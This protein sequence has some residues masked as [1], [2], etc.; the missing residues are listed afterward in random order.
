MVI[1]DATVPDLRA[2]RVRGPT[3][4]KERPRPPSKIVQAAVISTSTPHNIPL[5]YSPVTEA[6]T[7]Q[8]TKRPLQAS[9]LIAKLKLKLKRNLV[10]KNKKLKRTKKIAIKTSKKTCNQSH[11]QH[12]DPIGMSK[13]MAQ[14][15]A[16]HAPAPKKKLVGQLVKNCLLYTSPS[17]RDRQKSRMPSSA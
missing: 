16:I 4:A 6:K 5:V 11:L 3:T 15:S 2:D 13:I 1:K 17:P 14:M 7:P 10:Y 12:Q 8:R 9:S